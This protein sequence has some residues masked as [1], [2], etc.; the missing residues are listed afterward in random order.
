[1]SEILFVALLGLVV[2]GPK[3]LSTLG[4][5]AVR[6]LAQFKTDSADFKSQILSEMEAAQTPKRY[7]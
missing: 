2:F 7:Y 3:K 1:M 6:A 5:Q 4:Q